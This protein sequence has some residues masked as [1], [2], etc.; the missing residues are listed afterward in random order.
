MRSGR[1]IAEELGVDY[2]KLT[3]RE[4]RLCDTFGQMEGMI[5]F[6]GSGAEL[7]H[8]VRRSTLQFG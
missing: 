3:P 2:D 1:E 7:I 4:R 6:H 8:H 5:P